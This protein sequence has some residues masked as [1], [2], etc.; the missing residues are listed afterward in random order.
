MAS[1]LTGQLAQIRQK[2]T[3]P[4]NLKQKKREHSQ[5]LLFAHRVALQQDFKSIFA[6]CRRGFDELCRL[7]ERFERFSRS[8]F[9]DES[10]TQD[11]TQLEGT[12][13]RRTFES[14]ESF[15]VLVNS[16][17]RTECAL[18]SIEWLIRRFRY[19]RTQSLDLSGTI[20]ICREQGKHQQRPHITPDLPAAFGWPSF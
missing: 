3:N 14:I 4:L 5:S 7:D 15:F 9:S 11:R 8:L 13:E 16:R 6:I 2:S 1:T 17:V 12:I 10:L 19:S 18:Q 20:L